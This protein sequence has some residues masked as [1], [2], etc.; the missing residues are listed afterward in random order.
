MGVG[1]LMILNL[2]LM[3][4]DNETRSASNDHPDSLPALSKTIQNS[5][6]SLHEKTREQ[7]LKAEEEKQKGLAALGFASAFVG[8][9]KMQIR[10]FQWF[11]DL[12]ITILNIMEELLYW[13]HRS[14]GLVFLS[15]WVGAFLAS[16]INIKWFVLF[17]GCGILF[18]T[19]PGNLALVK[20]MYGFFESNSIFAFQL[21]VNLFVRFLI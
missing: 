4:V 16:M 7:Q 5:G 12:L 10:Q 3:E 17:G 8:A 18:A 13:R 2:S 20:W 21:I 19:A 1:F 11:L 15:C 14:S 9:Y 6:S